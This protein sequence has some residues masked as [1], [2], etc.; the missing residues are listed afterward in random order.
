MG[1]TKS[2]Q[3]LKSTVIS[4]WLQKRQSE[5]QTAGALEESKHHVV[6]GRGGRRAGAWRSVGEWRA[7]LSWQQAG[8]WAAPSHCL[9]DMDSADNQLP[10]K[11][12]QM[13][14]ASQ[15][16]P[17]FQPRGTLSTRSSHTLARLLTWR[18]GQI[19][20]LCYFKVLI[21]WQFLMQQ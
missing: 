19:I 12:T 18:D 7:V 21:L 8:R 10:C 1:L 13:R 3:S 14:T 20:N 2:R 11:R 17:W 5:R 15:R 9:K 6:N 4:S 16:A